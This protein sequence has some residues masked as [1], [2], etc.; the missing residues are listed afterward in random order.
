V[1]PEI[2]GWKEN[3]LQTVAKQT[4]KLIET[5]EGLVKATPTKPFTAKVDK[6]KA[7]II[8]QQHKLTKV[9]ARSYLKLLKALSRGIAQVGKN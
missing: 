5:F 4:E 9:W 6:T 8:K 1:T 7:A 3:E 2:L